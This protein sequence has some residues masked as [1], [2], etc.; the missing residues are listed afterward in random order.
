MSS[1]KKLGNGKRR[2][3][4]SVHH[5]H[6]IVNWFLNSRLT[7]SNTN[8]H[9]QQ[10]TNIAELGCKGHNRLLLRY[11]CRTTK[12]RSEL[13]THYRRSGNKTCVC[14]RKN[15]RLPTNDPA[16]DPAKS[17]A[18]Q[19]LKLQPSWKETAKETLGP[20]KWINLP[21]E[22]FSQSNNTTPWDLINRITMSDQTGHEMLLTGPSKDSQHSTNW[23]K[24]IFTHSRCVQVWTDGSE[25]RVS[26]AEEAE[27]WS[28]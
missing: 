12:R 8:N 11:A 22:N 4:S 13:D 18:R 15:F 2:I 23:N 6:I 1:R 21:C 24:H 5:L 3:Q 10:T 14:L 28:S 27:F 9:L 26:P 16:T 25:C 17:C 19:G 20:H 7:A